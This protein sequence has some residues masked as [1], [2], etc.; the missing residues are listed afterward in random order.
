MLFL[1]KGL[2]FLRSRILLIIVGVLSWVLYFFCFTKQFPLLKYYA[3]RTDMGAITQNSHTGFLLYV[4]PFL[5]LFALLALAC[6]DIWQRRD[7]AALWLI[8]GFGVVFAVTMAFVYPITAVDVYGYIVQ[9]LVLLDYHA[10]PLV[11]PAAT[12][13]E[14]SMMFMAG[15]WAKAPAP[16]GPLAILLGTIPTLLVGRNVLAN[17]L[18][19]KCIFSAALLFEAY[20][21]YKI[22]LNYAPR[23]ALVGALFMVWNPQALFEYSAN[24]HN[25]VILMLFVLLA[26]LALT[27]KHHVLAFGLI[28]AS[29]LFKYTTLLLVPLFFLYSLSQLTPWS[30]RLSYAGQSLL[31]GVGLT[32]ALFAPFWAGPATFQN[33]LDQDNQ[34]ISSF[35]NL[36]YEA[37][38]TPLELA[39][40]Y[41]RI[42]F[43]L[44]YLVA[45]YLATRSLRGL[46]IAGFLTMFCFLA[47]ATG[48][49]EVWYVIW[50]LTFAVLIPRLEFLL[51]A[52]LLA[53]GALLTHPI[54]AYLWVWSGRSAEMFSMASTLSYLC[55]FVPALLLLVCAGL[56]RLFA[57]HKPLTLPEKAV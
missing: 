19:F 57:P 51:A 56:G 36:L 21:V 27:R 11:T 53:F 50:P 38:H 41:G 1:K 52:G 2:L 48:K 39:K 8:L 33:L 14:D 31:L 45:L 5:T 30:K 17:L 35:S 18:L 22:L 12:F 40:F 37:L 23:F 3:T 49:F 7:G 29:V 28:I 25:D 10:N 16:Y 32:V 42:I 44:A 46:L 47:F 55:A 15:G 9:N 24:S 13:S 26:I 4:L 20:L 34:Y 6:W 43:A 54:F